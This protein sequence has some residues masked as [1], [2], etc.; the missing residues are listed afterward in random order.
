MKWIGLTG[1]IGCGKSTALKIFQKLGFNTVSADAIVHSLYQEEE[2]VL[3]VCEALNIKRKK[4]SLSKIS[5]EIFSNKRLL[6]LLENV[7]HPK[8]RLEVEKKYKEFQKKNIPLS[9]YEVPLLF[10]KKME[11]DFDYTICI[12]A[13]SKIQLK[14]I[15]ERNPS[16]TDKE[17]E[18]RIANQLPLSEKA[19]KADFYIDNSDSLESLRKA[20]KNLLN[21]L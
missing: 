1:G 5:E 20:C 4:F 16:W 12:G 6:K 11:K 15:Q 14:R 9:F 21:K 2:F 7:V 10:E 19:K 3:R 17:I 18:A 13:L 8:V